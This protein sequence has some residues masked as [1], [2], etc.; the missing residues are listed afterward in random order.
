M[1]ER[2]EQTSA[3]TIEAA[4][5]VADALDRHGHAH[6]AET[7]RDAL[8]SG[9]SGSVLRI[10]LREACQVVL[11]AVEAIDPVCAAMVEELR[12]KVDAWT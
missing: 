3:T 10:A 4:H 2:P 7:L 8:A 5:A 9:H 11:T 12:L 6:H 1:T